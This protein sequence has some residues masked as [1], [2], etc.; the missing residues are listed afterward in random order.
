MIDTITTILYTH[1]IME[2]KGLVYGYGGDWTEEVRV[3]GAFWVCGEGCV[4]QAG[5]HDELRASLAGGC[6][7]GAPMTGVPVAGNW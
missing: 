1:R 2:G 4:D 3:L 6:D 7:L 5:I